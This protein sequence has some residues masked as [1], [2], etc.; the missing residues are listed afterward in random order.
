M[1]QEKKVPPKPEPTSN[2]TDEKT[3]SE[4]LIS[5]VIASALVEIGKAVGE[6]VVEA[7]GK[8]LEKK[9]SGR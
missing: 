8:L 3:E 6:F 9:L 5:G 4:A 7:A 2:S 1:P